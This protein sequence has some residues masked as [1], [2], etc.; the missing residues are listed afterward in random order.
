MRRL[1]CVSD[2]RWFQFGD[3]FDWRSVG[4]DDL[5][6]YLHGFNDDNGFAKSNY[7][8]LPKYAFVAVTT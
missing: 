7:L 6:F 8:V 5:N 2:Y 3:I 1:R 4:E